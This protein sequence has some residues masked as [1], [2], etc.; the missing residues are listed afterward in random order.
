[1]KSNYD[2]PLRYYQPIEQMPRVSREEFCRDMDQI[3]DRVSDENT[4]FVLTEEGKPDLLLCP[5]KWF[6][7]CF[8]DDFGCVINGAVR[9]ALGRHT[10][11]PGVVN[12]FVRRYLPILDNKTLSVI[13]EDIEREA[14]MDPE[15]KY[16]DMWISLYSDIK[17]ELEHRMEL[18]RVQG[19]PR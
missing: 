17:T 18:E 9:Y 4:G 12:D 15:L 6:S 19:E 10:Y 2:I 3:L 13:I 5:A 11:M 16:R 7:F 14:N 1:M 8:D